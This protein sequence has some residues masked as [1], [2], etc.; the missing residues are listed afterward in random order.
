MDGRNGSSAGPHGTTDPIFAAT[1]PSEGSDSAADPNSESFDY[2]CSDFHPLCPFPCLDWR[3]KWAN[4]I[5]AQAIPRERWFADRWVRLAVRIQERLG[6]PPRLPARPD[7]ALIAP[8]LVAAVAVRFEAKPRRRWEIEAR[9]L[10][11]QS[12][13]VIGRLCAL[14]PL[15]VR[16][17]ER[18]FFQIAQ[19]RHARSYIEY[20]V[21]GDRAYTAFA[22]DDTEVLWCLCGYSFGPS[23]LGIAIR[24]TDTSGLIQFD[25]PGGDFSAEE[26]RFLRHFRWT[27]DATN[28]P[29]E[30][31]GPEELVRFM[32]QVLALKNTS[33]EPVAQASNSS[34]LHDGFD[35]LLA[36][37]ADSRARTANQATAQGANSRPQKSLPAPAAR[38]SIEAQGMGHRQARCA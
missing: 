31:F 34:V 5:R 22:R 32:L 13:D 16:V 19:A 24:A 33:T 27:I 21:L 26:R 6:N 2:L 23:A 11:G 20:R 3:W 14:S 9:L 28:V 8:E 10:A 35:A 1:T 37:S 38:L 4:E 25:N 15:A 30:E 36:H 29:L 18:L 7:E 17:F 12:F